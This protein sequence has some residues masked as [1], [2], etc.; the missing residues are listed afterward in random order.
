MC[1]FAYDIMDELA[2]VRQSWHTD[3]FLIVIPFYI[4]ANTRG[5]IVNVLNI[6]ITM[7]AAVHQCT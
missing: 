5:S 4:L 7:T 6:S 1:C 3:Y 2:V